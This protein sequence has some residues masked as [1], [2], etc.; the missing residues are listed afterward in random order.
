MPNIIK[1]T[2]NT[3]RDSTRKKDL[4]QGFLNSESSNFVFIKINFKSWEVEFEAVL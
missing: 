4:I 3:D 2:Q 1:R